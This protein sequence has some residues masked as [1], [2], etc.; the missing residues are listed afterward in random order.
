[1]SPGLLTSWN[2]GHGIFGLDFVDATHGWATTVDSVTFTI[3]GGKTW[4]PL[5]VPGLTEWWPAALSFS[6]SLDGWVVGQDYDMVGG[7]ITHT[8]DG[9]RIIHGGPEGAPVVD[10]GTGHPLRVLGQG[11]HVRALAL[12]RDGS[13]V[14]LAS[15]RSNSMIPSIAASAQTV[16][17]ADRSG[18]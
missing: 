4:S 18:R 10:A 11:Q 14:A 8:P 3:D 15:S 12:S 16:H 17:T 2:Y 1:M 6:T 9:G 13:F 7:E 5:A